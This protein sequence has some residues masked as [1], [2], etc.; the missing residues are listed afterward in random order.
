MDIRDIK[1]FDEAVVALG[2]GSQL[3]VNAEDTII[4]V[5]P[6]VEQHNNPELMKEVLSRVG[7]KYGKEF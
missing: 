2:D 1:V 4:A 6:S 7:K 3:K 5:A